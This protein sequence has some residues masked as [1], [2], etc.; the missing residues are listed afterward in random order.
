MIFHHSHEKKKH[1]IGS[2]SCVIDVIFRVLYESLSM[3]YAFEHGFQYFR[4]MPH[5]QRRFLPIT[6]EKEDGCSGIQ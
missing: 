4:T 2:T 6:R 3:V 1:G 5:N